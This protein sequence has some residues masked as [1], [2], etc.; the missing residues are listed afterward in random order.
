MKTMKCNHCE[1]NIILD[2]FT[3]TC[4]T[5]G[6]DYNNFGQEL[7][8]REEWGWETGENIVDIMNGSDDW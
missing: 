3:N 5:C 7:A 1:D 6:T 4:D 8:P 2:S